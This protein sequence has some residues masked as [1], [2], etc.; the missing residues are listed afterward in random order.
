MSV[1]ATLGAISSLTSL[2]DTNVVSEWRRP[3]PDRQVVD[4][5]KR[6]DIG[7]VFLS[8]ITLLEI[9]QG[10]DRLPLGGRRDGLEAWLVQEVPYFFEGRVLPVDEAVAD[11][12]G[13]IRARAFAS[14]R[15]IP[16]LDAFLAATAEVHGLTLVTR[17]TR[18]FEVWGGPVFNPWIETGPS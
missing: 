2:L 3:Q 18:D 9:R 16:V 4:W 10:I 5:L 6:V 12:C 13:R 17:N 8:V 7:S 15:P 1:I 11:V 14:G